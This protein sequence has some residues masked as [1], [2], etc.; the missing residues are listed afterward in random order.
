MDMLVSL[1][2]SVLVSLLILSGVLLMVA[3]ALG[4][5]IL[6]KT[7][8]FVGLFF[9]LLFVISL[10][11]DFLSS[12]SPLFLV[13]GF[14]AVSALAFWVRQRSLSSLRRRDGPH[15]VERSPVMPRH[16]PGDDQ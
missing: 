13:L 15:V 12:T 9:I 3:P 6:T 1:F 16:I 2:G 5:R 10:V 4:G 11:R 8:A 7:A 14:T